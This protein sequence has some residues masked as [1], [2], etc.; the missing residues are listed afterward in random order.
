M[1]GKEKVFEVPD[2]SRANEFYREPPAIQRHYMVI[3][4]AMMADDRITVGNRQMRLLRSG[5]EI[6][7]TLKQCNK[8]LRKYKCS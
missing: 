6:P 8:L 2:V 4:D 3:R 5:F 7:I 1:W